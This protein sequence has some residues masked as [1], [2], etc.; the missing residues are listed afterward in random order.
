MLRICKLLYYLS[1]EGID[2]LTYIEKEKSTSLT[3]ILGIQYQFNEHFVIS[4]DIGIELF[5]EDGTIIREQKIEI[6]GQ[7]TS[8]GS[9]RLIFFFDT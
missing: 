1:A 7:K 2:R 4:G 8:Q 3:G 9:I 6:D 5:I